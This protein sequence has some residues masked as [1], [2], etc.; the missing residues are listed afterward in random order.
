MP[1]MMNKH[2]ELKT[3]PFKPAHIALLLHMGREV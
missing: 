3:I 2:G 1:R